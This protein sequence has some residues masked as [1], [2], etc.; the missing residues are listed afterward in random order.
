MIE[1]LIDEVYLKANKVKQDYI[2]LEIYNPLKRQVEKYLYKDLNNS[3]DYSLI[4]GRE[5][6]SR[7]SY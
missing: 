1:K 2:Y 6:S 3:K 4:L 5:T 7:P